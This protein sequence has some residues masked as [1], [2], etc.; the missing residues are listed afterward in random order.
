MAGRGT[1]FVASLCV[2]TC[3]FTTSALYQ[4]G[5]EIFHESLLR[6]SST[7]ND[8]ILCLTTDDSILARF[9]KCDTLLSRVLTCLS[10]GQDDY[11]SQEDVEEDNDDEIVT[12]RGLGRCINKCLR[13]RGR[14]TFIQC[15]SMCH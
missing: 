6:C 14:M 4:T 13:G 11:Y 15:K 5:D 10:R 9:Q 12:K 7:L 3:A 2:C 1:L 8:F